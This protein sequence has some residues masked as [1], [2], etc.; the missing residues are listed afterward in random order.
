MYSGLTINLPVTHVL[1]IILMKTIFSFARASLTRSPWPKAFFAMVKVKSHGRGHYRVGS[2]GFGRHGRAP[3]E[4]ALPSAVTAWAL[5]SKLRR[6]DATPGPGGAGDYILGMTHSNVDTSQ[7]PYPRLRRKISDAECD[8][9]AG[10]FRERRKAPDSAR[11]S[12][13]IYLKLRDQ[14]EQGDSC[15]C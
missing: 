12:Y 6:P 1:S 9:H 2:A 14:I 3:S 4:R 10:P 5:I 13:A 15:R 7:L 11:F 8:E